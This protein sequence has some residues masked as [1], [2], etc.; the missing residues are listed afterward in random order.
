[1]LQLLVSSFKDVYIYIY[2]CTHAHTRVQTTCSV[3]C[4]CR[5]PDIPLPFLILTVHLTILVVRGETNLV[6]IQMLDVTPDPGVAL[7]A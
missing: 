4:I 2:I 5:T 7:T 6:S 3:T 1:M